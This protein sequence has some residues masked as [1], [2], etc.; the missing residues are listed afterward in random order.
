VHNNPLLFSDPSG[1]CPNC[2]AALIG[3]LIG[4][5]GNAAV[6][7]YNGGN[8]SDVGMAFL[9]GGLTGAAFAATAGAGGS[10][11]GWMASGG[12]SGGITAGGTVLA[13]GGT[14]SQAG[15]AALGGALVGS[16]TG[17]IGNKIALNNALSNLRLVGGSAK[18]SVARGD[19]SG[20]LAAA[21]GSAGIG[22]LDADSMWKETSGFFEQMGSCR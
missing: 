21:T 1:N 16:V 11:A 3:G 22:M 10:V 20:S 8:A 17:G 5:V 19:M 14:L 2:I 4:G 13:N 9:V 15:D 6:T 7:Y 18:S 12:A